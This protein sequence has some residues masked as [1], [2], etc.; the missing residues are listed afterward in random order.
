VWVYLSPGKDSY[1]ISYE[2]ALGIKDGDLRWHIDFNSF[3]DRY[4]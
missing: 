2:R 3:N 4:F 1:D